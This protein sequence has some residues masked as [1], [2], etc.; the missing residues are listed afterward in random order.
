VELQCPPE[1]ANTDGSELRAAG[2]RS[3]MST[4]SSP[5]REALWLRFVGMGLILGGFAAAA[6]L[7]EAV[8]PLLLLENS[9][10]S[11]MAPWA[12]LW[13]IAANGIVLGVILLLAG[14]REVSLRRSGRAR[15]GAAVRLGAANILFVCVAVAALQ[16]SGALDAA[17]TRWYVALPLLSGFV[18][19]ARWGIAGFRS[20]WKY[21]AR[22]AEEALARDPRPPV[23]YLRSFEADPQMVVTGHSR[24]ARAAG[25]LSY[26]TSVSPEQELAF[27]LERVGPVIAIGKPGERL[28][29]LG[30]A[31]RYVADDQWREVVHRMMRDAALVVIRAGET[32][33]LW[34]EIEQAL[35][36]CLPGRVILVVLGPPG[37]LPGF[38]R[39]FVGAFGAPVARSSPPPSRYTVLLRLIAPL[40]RSTGR[41]IYFDRHGTAHEEPLQFRLTWSGFALVGF[42]PYRDSLQAAFRAVFADLGVSWLPKR[43]LTVA[44]LLALGGGIFGLHHFYMGHVRR[45]LWYLAFF[46][47][48][49][50]MVLGWIDAARL[51]LLDDAGFQ[52]RLKPKT[53]PTVR[54]DALAGSE[55]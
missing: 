14:L 46:W 37:S 35:A 43:S 18:L 55:V 3:A 29:E 19:A 49:I 8:D 11:R 52:R 26:A 42:R 23:L 31:R 12:T 47:I 41:I 24:A 20:G 21:D 9:D 32:E 51:A 5:S 53:S 17:V 44:V 40:G 2:S 33:N 38:E 28:P 39:R 16:D 22:S 36:L 1:M 48:A 50:P 30:A 15:R 13:V 7:G 27:I 25:L 54:P 4:A 10:W 6:A 34:W 45:G